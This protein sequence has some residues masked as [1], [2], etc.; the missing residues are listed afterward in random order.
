[1][2]IFDTAKMII[3]ILRGVQNQVVDFGFL[4]KQLIIHS[5]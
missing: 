5:G 4:K 1:V 2:K 3:L